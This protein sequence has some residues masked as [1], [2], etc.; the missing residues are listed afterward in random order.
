[1]TVGHVTIDAT[2]AGADGILFYGAEGS[3]KDSTI[4]GGQNGVEAD[5]S[6]GAVFGTITDQVKVGGTTITGYQHAGVYAHG[7]LKLNVLLAVIGSP[8]PASGPSPGCDGVGSHGSTGEPHQASDAELRLHCLAP[9]SSSEARHGFALAAEGAMFTGGDADFDCA[10]NAAT[11]KMTAIP[12][13]PIRRHDTW[14]TTRSNGAPSGDRRSQCPVATP[15][16]AEP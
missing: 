10:S 15:A 8:E 14:S 11:A 1:M 12:M 13:Q 2:G 7:D 5:N 9:V 16:P 6:V 4:Q 3:V